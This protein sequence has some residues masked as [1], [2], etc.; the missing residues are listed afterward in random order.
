MEQEYQSLTKSLFRDLGAYLLTLRPLRRLDSPAEEAAEE[1][2]LPEQLAA[3][4]LALGLTAKD[5]VNETKLQRKLRSLATRISKRQQAELS[6]LLGRSVSQASAATVDLWVEEQA[7]ALRNQVNG[8][9]VRAQELTRTPDVP[10]EEVTQRLGELSKKEAAKAAFFASSAV[11]ALNSQVQEQ[12]AP[13]SGATHYRWS[14]TIDERTRDWH[15]DLDGTIQSWAEP[16]M[17]GG[18]SAEYPG[19]PGSGI[20]CRCIAIPLT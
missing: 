17:G 3:L 4:L 1:V 6:R 9:L 7:L 8:F 2:E 20:S 5:L 18:T 19:H 12:L 10:F 14:T 15:A 13:V 16:P 11:L